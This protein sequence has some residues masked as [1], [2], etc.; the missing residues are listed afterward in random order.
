VTVAGG[1]P[2]VAEAGAAI[3]GLLDAQVRR[4]GAAV[5]LQDPQAATILR[6]LDAADV[7][8]AVLPDKGV[9]AHSGLRS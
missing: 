5:D 8:A 1:S 4:I 3:A 2:A 9:C 6:E 7:V